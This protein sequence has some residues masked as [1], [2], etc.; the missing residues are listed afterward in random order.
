MRSRSRPNDASGPKLCC[1]RATTGPTAVSARS[2][3]SSMATRSNGSWSAAGPLSAT[4]INPFGARFRPKPSLARHLIDPVWG[5]MFQY[6][7]KL[8]WSGPHY[9]K[10]LNIQRDALR[11]YV[12]A[13]QIGHDPADLA[14]AHDIARW[15]MDFMRAP[16]GAF[17]TSQDA[18]AGPA[19]PGDAFYAKSDAQRRAGPQPPIDR[20]FY[21]RENGWAIASLAALYDVTGDHALLEAAVR[22]LDW[23]V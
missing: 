13:W 19:L 17:Y 21:A 23:T 15:L 6:S 8:D 1:S 22:A 4:P 9:E 18:D 3:S 2:I 14:A 7:E 10:L 11:A 5:G 20:S 16:S 12:L